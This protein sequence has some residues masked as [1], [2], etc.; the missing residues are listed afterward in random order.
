MILHSIKLCQAGHIIYASYELYEEH[1]IR[2][3]GFH[4]TS[5]KYVAYRAA[6]LLNKPIEELKIV[7][8]HLGNG[9]SICAV[10]GGKSI[11]TSMGF[12]PLQV[13]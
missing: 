3:Y 13:W 11:D 5:H 12:T 8:S 4:G 1:K 10:K 9:A 7:T 6:E 2:R